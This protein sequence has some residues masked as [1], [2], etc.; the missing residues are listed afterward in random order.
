M[1]AIKGE[2]VMARASGWLMLWAIGVSASL[3]GAQPLGCL[4]EPEQVAEVG[5]PVIGVVE[6]I[7]VERG[8]RVAKRQVIAVLRDEVF[9]RN[10]A[11]T[12]ARASSSASRCPPRTLVRC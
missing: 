9:C 7:R 8:D 4:I 12:S 10:W 3:H 6:A 2:R 5:S 1:T 11:V